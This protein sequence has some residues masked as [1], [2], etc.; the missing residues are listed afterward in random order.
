[1]QSTQAEYKKY[2]R[3]FLDNKKILIFFELLEEAIKKGALTQKEMAILSEA[4]LDKSVANEKQKQLILNEIQAFKQRE[5]K[6]AQ[7]ENQEKIKK[8]NEMRFDILEKKEEILKQKAIHSEF[9]K[10]GLFKL[11]KLFYFHLFFLIRVPFLSEIELG[12]APPKE[13]IAKN[14]KIDYEQYRDHMDMSEFFKKGK[15]YLETAKKKIEDLKAQ[16][17]KIN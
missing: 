7:I 11:K 16:V 10:K 12:N 3:I 6:Q 8:L 17:I 14:F 5:M 9:M 4:Y 2:I 13:I 1:M 15:E